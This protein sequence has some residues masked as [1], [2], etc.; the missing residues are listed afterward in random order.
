MY[1]PEGHLKV[2]VV[3]RGDPNCRVIY[4][5]EADRQQETKAGWDCIGVMAKDV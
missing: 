5:E 4:G 3:E 2:D 1:T